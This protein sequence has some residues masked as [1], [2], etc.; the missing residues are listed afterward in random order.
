MYKEARKCA[1]FVTPFGQHA[2]LLSSLVNDKYIFRG[3]LVMYLVTT[4]I[5]SSLLLTLSISI[6]VY[7]CFSS[8]TVKC[9]VHFCF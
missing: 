2:C 9:V 3:E 4:G 5:M 1:V 6:V 8:E 7:F